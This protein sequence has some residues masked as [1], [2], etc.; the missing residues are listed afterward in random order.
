MRRMEK[1][2][3]G[4]DERLGHIRRNALRYCALRGL[5]FVLGLMSMA[6]SVLVHLVT[7]PVELDASFNRALP[8]LRAGQYVDDKDQNAA[9]QVLSAAALTYLAASL[10]SLLNVWRWMYLWRGR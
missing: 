4:E 3:G 5:M 8:L 1:N 2:W 7:L 10:S 6:L 9:R